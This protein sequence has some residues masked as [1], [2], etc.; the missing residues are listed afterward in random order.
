ML[1]ITRQQLLEQHLQLHAG[2]LG[3]E[4]QVRAHPAEG[5]VVVRRAM[6]VEAVRIGELALVVVGRR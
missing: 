1:L 4:A 5:D 2:Q 3:T 6:D